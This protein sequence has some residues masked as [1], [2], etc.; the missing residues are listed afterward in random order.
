[1]D[2]LCVCVRI[3]KC[4]STSLTH[5][6]NAAFSNRRTFYLPHTLN[7]DASISSFQ[8][9]RFLRTRA[10]NLLMRYRTT[11]I[12][13]AF[14]II[15]TWATDGDLL[16]G[17]HIDFHSV[18]EHIDRK[19]KMIT[20]FREPAKRVRSEYNYSRLT[21]LDRGPFRR[22]DSGM[23]HKAAGKYDFDGF[24]DFLLD[25]RQLYGDVAARYIDWDGREGLDRYFANNV[26]HSGV[27]E[28]SGAFEK[29]LS[30]KMGLKLTFPHKNRTR[31]DGETGV[32][33]AQRSK[34]EKIYSRDFA[35]YEWQ[36]E[37]V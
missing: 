13:K 8:D 20:I 27:L 33:A 37:H 29:G 10:R 23:R 34:I 32:T 15:S 18:R 22:I 25:N 3:P 2:F 28:R 30:E 16:A 7:L 24:L 19:V 31:K 6:V 1:M 11:S 5:I 17:G 26:F 12:A 9:M 35:L 14:D 36:L 21:Y 4:G